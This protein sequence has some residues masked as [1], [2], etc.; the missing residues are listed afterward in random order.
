M[1]LGFLFSR[2]FLLVF[3]GSGITDNNSDLQGLN[4]LIYFNRFEAENKKAEVQISSASLA[5]TAFISFM[6]VT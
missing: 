5:L 1:W 2:L 3:M 6:A 4:I